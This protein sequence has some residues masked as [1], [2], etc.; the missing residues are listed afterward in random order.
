ME[1]GVAMALR[2]GPEFA[3]SLLARDHEMKEFFGLDG[4]IGFVDVS[5]FLS[6]D[7]MG[8]QRSSNT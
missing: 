4:D 8:L 6:F 7:G 5:S 3:T 2:M 1:S